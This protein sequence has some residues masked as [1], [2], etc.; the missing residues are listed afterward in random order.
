ML[1][2][3]WRYF[4]VASCQATAELERVT[5]SACHDQVPDVA[6]ERYKNRDHQLKQ[7]ENILSW[8]WERRYLWWIHS[9]VL[10]A[11]LVLLDVGFILHGPAGR[12][13]SIKF[14]SGYVPWPLVSLVFPA[15][16]AKLQWHLR[17]TR[18]SL[19]RAVGTPST[20]LYWACGRSLQDASLSQDSGSAGRTSALSFPRPYYYCHALY[21]PNPVFTFH[22][23]TVI[24]NPSNII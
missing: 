9:W 12:R 5:L 13:I 14:I 3:L 10:L 24:H 15:G 8:P 1:G 21:F 23:A 11:W 20:N 2:S 7:R 6:G 4:A 22:A 19:F 18:T 17:C 16:G